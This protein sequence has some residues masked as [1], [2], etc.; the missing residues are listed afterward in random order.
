MIL[1][2]GGT[3][4]GR[5]AVKVLDEAGTPFYYATKGSEQQ[6]ESKHGIRLSGGLDEQSMV[7]F[8]RTNHIRL[9]VDAAHPF[10]TAL[11]ANVDHTATTLRI[12]VVRLERIYP[13]PSPSSIVCRDYDDAIARLEAKGITRLLALTG[14]NTIGKLTAYWKRHTTY[15]RIL[16]R[17]ESRNIAEKWGFPST[18]L[19]W[20][21]AQ[22]PTAE[23]ISQYRPQAILT[24]ESGESGGYSEKE[25]ACRDAGIPFFVISRP[26]LPPHF[27]TVTGE[28][29]LRRS[30]ERLV[31]GFYTLRSGFTTGSCA[32]AASRAALIA[33]LGY[34][35][36][37]QVSFHLPNGERMQMPIDR[38]EKGVGWAKAWVTKDAGDDPDVTHGQTITS[39]IR[40]TPN[41]GIHFLQGE[42]VGRV[43]L[44]GIGLPIGEPAINRVPRE[45]MRRELSM[46]YSGGLEV[47]ISVPNGKEL[48]QKTF[49]PK[50]G[51]VDGISILGTL[52]IVRP[53]SSAAFV[54]SIQR[55]MEVAVALGVKQ[56]V[57][58]SG[59]KSER[60]VKGRYPELPSQAF[61]HY[62]NFIGETL[63]VASR[64]HIREVALG[65][66]LGKA[67]KLA[68]GNLDT[69]SKKVTLDKDFL[70]R[71]AADAGCSQRT[72]EA[73]DSLTLARELWERLPSDDQEK[74]FDAMLVHCHQHCAKAYPKG[75][76]TLLLIS[77]EG[78][79]GYESTQTR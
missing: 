54:E 74:F 58:N 44:P 10:A 24:K 17:D 69:H 62:G 2:L 55:E 32:T 43:T 33:L 37:T 39:T 40:F 1:I 72:Q 6:I 15:F 70:R 28:Y 59:A 30:V 23:L 29:G 35:P 48:A 18:Q 36:S 47:I 38:I 13:I 50:L 67:V 26:T 77:E 5:L 9:L 68:A 4:E 7:D 73:I 65:I 71:L 42:G 56:V 51:I 16:D 14:V 63:E 8:C 66:M 3:T 53:F 34:E 49:N 31:P 11:H 12:P 25:A 79:I 75:T 78:N 21:E 57:I 20:Y 64:L 19:L 41:S 60:I 61:I 27:I 76:L 45:M 52:G 46:L 22:T